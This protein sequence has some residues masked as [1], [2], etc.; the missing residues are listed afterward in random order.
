[1]VTLLLRL[2]LDV[3]VATIAGAS[4]AGHPELGPALVDV[5]RRESRLELVS[6]HAID[7][8]WSASLRPSGCSGRDGWSTRGAHGQM[9]AYALRYAPGWARCAPWLLDVPIVSAWLAA[10][11]ASSWR[12]RQHPRCRSWLATRDGPAA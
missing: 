4:L 1:M 5:A 3:R 10:R 2:A 9:A 11:R 6:V 8:R 7:S 12:C